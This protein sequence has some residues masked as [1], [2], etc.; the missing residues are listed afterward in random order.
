M[1]AFPNRSI[2]K[3]V[4]INSISW[5]GS[6]FA[7][8]NGDVHQEEEAWLSYTKPYSLKKTNLIYTGVLCSHFAFE[9]QRKYLDSTDI[10]EQYRNLII[11][12]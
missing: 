12:G 6:E 9:K 10:L 2:S 11:E 8:F 4:S 7:K 5:F 1:Y 3:R